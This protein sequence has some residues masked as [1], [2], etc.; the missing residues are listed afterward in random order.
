MTQDQPEGPDRGMAARL[1]RVRARLH[2]HPVGAAVTKT[3]VAV[4]G[5][6]VLVLGVV[7]IVTPG[8]ALVLIPAGLA[9]LATEFEFARRW[10]QTARD[11]A[12]EAKARSQAL[13]PRVRRR[14]RLAATLGVVVLLGAVAGYVTLFD[15][16]GLA[17][18]GWDRLQDVVGWLPEL[19]GM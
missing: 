6:A 16:P 13:D 11:K 18:S 8:P 5:T 15:W 9:I 1:R 4:V 10:L 3:V 19:P 12:R 17:V 2:A 14:R 7:M